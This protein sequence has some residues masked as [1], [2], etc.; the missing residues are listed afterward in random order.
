MANTILVKDI[1]ENIFKEMK[2]LPT[3]DEGYVCNHNGWRLKVKNPSYLAVAHLRENGIISPK[4]VAILV[5]EQDHDEYLFYFPEDHIFFDPYINAYKNMMK[6]ITESIEKHKDIQD[7]KTFA[8]IIK[9][10]PCKNILFCLR[11]GN[12]FESICDKM[13]DNAKERLLTEYIRTKSI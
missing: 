10:L 4:R 3:L 11:K 12:T 7:Q 8:L 9:D 1:P 6:D 2:N 13:N 5:F